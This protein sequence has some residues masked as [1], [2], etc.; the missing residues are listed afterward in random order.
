MSDRPA[1]DGSALGRVPAV[2][3]AARLFFALW[4]DASVRQQLGRCAAEVHR[5]CGGRQ[6]RD[7]QLHITLAFLGDVPID[8]IPE[9]CAAAHVPCPPMFTLRFSGA[10]YWPRKR[11]AWAAPEE[12]PASLSALAGR[13]TAVLNETGYRVD[14]RPYFPHVTLVRDARCRDL[15]SWPE[16]FEWRVADF[17][18]VRST[19]SPAGARY[20]VVSRWPL[21]TIR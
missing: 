20:D 15:P 14:S 2:P 12:I 5:A 4:P 21:K 11:L 9:V 18:L 3:P 6:I 1:G 7:E 17:V 10:G 8:D 16:G 13:L 19:R